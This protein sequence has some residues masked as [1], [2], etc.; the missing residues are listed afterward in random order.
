MSEVKYEEKI[1]KIEWQENCVCGDEW[2]K[3]VGM[4]QTN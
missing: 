4:I 1:N 3:I 2:E